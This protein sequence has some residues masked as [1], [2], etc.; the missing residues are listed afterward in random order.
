MIDILKDELHLKFTSP[1]IKFEENFTDTKHTMYLM[2]TAKK[3]TSRTKNSP[4]KCN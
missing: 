4:K 2:Y 3:K 1:N